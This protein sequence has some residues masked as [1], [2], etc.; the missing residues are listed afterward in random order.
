MS[1]NISWTHLPVYRS[2]TETILV[3]GVPRNVLLINGIIASFFILYFRFWYI[4][5]LNLIFHFVC[6]YLSRDDAQFF[7]CFNNYIYKAEYYS[8]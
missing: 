2:F 4:I 3:M 6:Q 1:N 8:T 5:G 7:D